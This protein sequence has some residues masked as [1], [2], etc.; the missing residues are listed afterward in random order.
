MTNQKNSAVKK[1]PLLCGLLSVWF[2]VSVQATDPIYQN[3]VYLTYTVPPQ[4]LPTID[5]TSFVNNNTFVLN[6]GP[7]PFAINPEVFETWNTVNYTNNGLMILSE[8]PTNQVSG[9]GFQFDT[10]T[11][12]QIS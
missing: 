10:Q 12:N 3:D 7:T 6:F 9:S 4:I 5:A 1:W 11:T 2:S 8:F